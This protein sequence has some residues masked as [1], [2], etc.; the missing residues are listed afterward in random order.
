MR[1]INIVAT[2]A[3]AC[4][5]ALGTSSAWADLEKY[6]IDPG[7]S[8][9]TFTIPHLG[10]SL[11]QGRFNTVN[12]QFSLDPAKAEGGSIGITVETSSVDSNHAERDKHLKGK[13]F[14]DV[15]KF[16][17]AEFTSKRIV[18]KDG[19]VQVSGDLTLHG[20]TKP[21][22]FEAKLVGTGPD[23]WG[24]FRRGYA[25]TLRIKRA[26][27]GISYNLGPAAEELDLGL[28]IEGIKQ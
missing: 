28:F 4:V 16:P 10:Y 20:V 1:K 9:V 27:F 19:K 21:V 22:A 24:G 5:L 12:G 23:P 17:K 2:T 25:G 14:L 3:F 11:L 13:D 8:F 6:K 18:E 15:E 26:D 7:H